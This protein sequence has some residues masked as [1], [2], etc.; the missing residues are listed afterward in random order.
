MTPATRVT[1]TMSV[2]TVGR[3][4]SQRDSATAA[5]VLSAVVV[6]LV[7]VGLPKSQRKAVRSSMMHV[8]GRF[9]VESGG[10][11]HRLVLLHARIVHAVPAA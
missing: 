2:P 1:V 9:T 7:Q 8:H 3:A 10:N 11:A 4:T 6:M 5:V